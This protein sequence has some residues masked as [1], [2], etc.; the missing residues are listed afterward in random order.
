MSEE[1]VQNNSNEEE[2]APAW[3]VTFGD[4]MS[5]LL[6]FFVLMLSF[7]EMDR[8]K[9]K[10]VSGSLANAFGIQRKTPVFESPKGQKIIAKEFDQAIIVNKIEEKLVKP[11]IVEIESNFQEMKD[12]IEIDVS[13]N[14]V[15]IR[16][17][18]ETTFDLGK[19]EIRPQMLPLLVKI[20]A[21]LKGTRGEILIAGHTDN[22][23]L[24]GGLYKSNLGLSMAR[25][26]SVA[27]FL[28]KKASIKPERIS[29]MGFGEHRPLASNHTRKGRE[30]N[31]RVE[32]ILTIYQYSDPAMVG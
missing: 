19:A 25:A 8:K 16:L 11:I 7:S 12:L 15:A 6:C 32:I 3:V 17:M 22:L 2:G 13:E 31:R 30:K 14:Q 27:E 4:L 24:R 26:A 28:L 1:P 18:G 9:Y 10:I 21:L 20:G 23:P 29:T 5:L